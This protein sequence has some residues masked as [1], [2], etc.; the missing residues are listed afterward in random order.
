MRKRTGYMLSAVLL[1]AVMSFGV[2][3]GQTEEPPTGT[4]PGGETPGGTTT[5]EETTYTVR[6]MDGD[7]EIASFEKK[8]SEKVTVPNNP[9]NG[10]TR[11]TFTGW[12]GLGD[13]AAGTQITVYGDA[14][15]YAN[16]YEQFGTDTVFNVMQRNMQ[17]AV[18]VDG[19][20]NDEAWADAAAFKLDE[21]GSTVKAL[22][23]SDALYLFADI[24]KEN[25]S[26]EDK[27]NIQLDLLHSEELASDTWD[28]VSWGGSYRGEPGP[29]VEGGYTVKAGASVSDDVEKS[30][31]WLSFGGYDNSEVKSNIS[32]EGYTVEFKIDLTNANIGDYTPYKGQ[33]I[34][35]SVKTVDGASA[36]ESFNGYAGHGPKSLSNVAL[37]TNPDNV[38][39]VWTVKEVRENYTV[40]VDGKEDLL[41]KDATVFGDLESDGYSVK[42]LWAAGKIYFYATLAEGTDSL[43]VTAFSKTVTF[44]QSGEQ[45]LEADAVALEAYS[46]LTVEVNGSVK[47]DADEQDS[48]IMLKSNEQNI[49]R[50]L[51]EAKRLAEGA[52]ITVDGVKDEAYGEKVADIATVSLIEAGAPQA[53]GVAYI[54][55]DDSFLYVFVEVTDADVSTEQRGDAHANDSV[56]VWLDT[57]QQ[58]PQGSTGWGDANRPLGL[59]RGEGGFRVLAGKIGGDSG[60][61]WLWDDPST[62]PETA[63]VLT[64]TGYT[65]EYAIPWACKANNDD[66]CDG[67]A[68]YIPSTGVNSWDFDNNVLGSPSNKLGEIIDIMININDD[69]GQDGVREGIVSLNSKGCDAWD[70]PY[71]LDQLKLV[72]AN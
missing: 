36:L 58:L 43:E 6:F 66:W 16:W 62:R 65:V 53:R 13:I 32:Q 11:Y 15:Y 71:V 26:A 37:V 41:Y 4:T 14:T 54:R 34:G 27:L 51:Y 48:L 45:M 35:L 70:R 1:A 22:W 33:E 49:G 25:A 2:A 3:C 29:M 39:T 57:C 67:F 10:D 47:F 44:T 21:A 60:Q 69:N 18:T 55:W 5:P 23:D 9:E 17:K 7:T 12:E 68:N 46:W 52:S 40:V 64:D 20:A 8:K 72:A 63:S 19:E 42:T 59:Y 31:E 38:G 30:F 61:H 50:H 28:G 24:K 56:E